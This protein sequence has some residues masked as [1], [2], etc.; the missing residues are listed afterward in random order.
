MAQ[1]LPF[2]GLLPSVERAAQVAAVPYD[3]VSSREAA[4]LAKGNP[5]S[6]LHVSRPEIDLEYG[7]DLHDERIYAQAAAAFQKLCKEV[8]LTLDNGKHLYLYQLQMGDHV[9]TGILGAAS[10]EEYRKGIIKKHEKT[11]QDKEDDRTRH[12]MELR[13]HTGPAF[14]TYRD[15]KNVDAIVAEITAETPYYS[16]VAPD[17]IEHKL[18]KAGPER[19]EKLSKIFKDEVPC[20]YIADGHHR[21]ASASRSGVTCKAANPHHTGKEDYNFFLAV[22]FPADQLRI[23]VRFERDGRRVGAAFVR[24]RVVYVPGRFDPGLDPEQVY[25]FAH[26]LDGGFPCDRIGFLGFEPDGRQQQQRRQQQLERKGS[27]HKVFVVE[28]GTG[29]LSPPCRS[30]GPGRP[31]WFNMLFRC[32]SRKS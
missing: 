19:T 25:V 17:G 11:R 16:F 31:S 29:F 28:T 7:I 1:L 30:L 22:A 18:W 15:N 8:P 23:R 6:F 20:F 24:P 10:A 13:S 5:Y 3:V 2:H 14:F 21:A 9:Q 32:V 4:E 27:A 12:V 26:A